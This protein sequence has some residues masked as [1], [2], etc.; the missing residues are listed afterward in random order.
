MKRRQRCARRR[1]SHAEATGARAISNRSPGVPQKPH[2]V[3]VRDPLDILAAVAAR[4][5]QRRQ[6]RRDPRSCARRTGTARGRMRRPDRIRSRSAARCRRAGRCDRCDSTTVSSVTPARSGVDLPRTQ[7]GTSIQAS[8]A[9]PMTAP[10]CDELAD[11]IVGELTVVGHER[12]AVGM[13]RPDRAAEKIERL[14]KAL[15]A[16]MGHVEDDAEPLHLAQQL[17]A[18]CGKTAARV[19]A[20]RVDAR[21]VVRRTHRAQALLVRALEVRERH[22]RVGP[23]E[24][25]DVPDRQAVSA[26]ALPARRGGGRAPA[27]S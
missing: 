1:K 25:Q 2:E 8:N 3:P 9:T 26:R 19:R 11:L 20:L 15:V 17:A 10:R 13:A 22:D 23:F 5:E 6:P 4:G 14:A 18:A 16:Q 27:R 24:A 7:P 12:P 21:P